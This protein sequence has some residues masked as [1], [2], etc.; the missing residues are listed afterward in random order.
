MA[1]ACQTQSQTL[2][3]KE[4]KGKSSLWRRSEPS[5][6][7]E[8]STVKGA[9]TDAFWHF[10]EGFMEEVPVEWGLQG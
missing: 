8:T 2:E 6:K 1:T 7:D 9:A 3:R 5:R 10:G 4:E